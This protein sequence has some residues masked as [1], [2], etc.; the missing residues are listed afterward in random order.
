[1]SF[2]W[3]RSCDAESRAIIGVFAA[4]A[5]IKLLLLAAF[6]PVSQPDTPGYVEYA[7]QIL[8]STKW[9]HD[10]DLSSSPTPITAMRMVGYPA[11]IAAAMAIA[12]PHWP[13]LLIALQFAMSFAAGWALY[14]LALELALPWPASLAAVATFML[15]LQLT[16]DQALLTDSINS[17]CLVIS[18]CLLA[19]GAVAR[20]PLRIRQAAL[21]GLLMALAFL[22]REALQFLVI[23][24]A[25]LM[26]A[27]LWLAGRGRLASSVVACGLVFAPL[28]V[29]VELYKAWNLHRTGERFVTTI[30]TLNLV[31]AIAQAAKYDP[32]VVA[33]DTPFDRAV[34]EQFKDNIYSEV[35]SFNDALF[36][37]GIRAT[38]LSRMSYAHYYRA[39]REQP[40]AMLTVLR[41]HISEREAK[42]TIRPLAAIC[43][44]IEWATTKPGCYDY[45]DLYRSL[46]FF[47]GLPWTA[48]AFFVLQTAE[49]A[50]A[51]ALFGGFLIGVPCLIVI[52]WFSAQGRVDAAILI[53]ASFWLL[54][55]GWFTAY[56]V[57]H[58]EDRYLAPVLPF[59]IL[60]GFY[61]WG[62]LL[63]KRRAPVKAKV[64]VGQL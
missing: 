20:R 10:A 30:S 27:R 26:A 62:E 57:V 3:F 32:A 63:L 39:W 47:Q 9:L 12:G 11:L 35:I 59:S 23:T 49:I 18:V 7:E 33:G 40:L 8:R 61:V 22:V 28:V 46:P 56:G 5:A 48:P 25:P 37:Q 34:R 21:A 50:L 1:M 19:S 15:S 24:L 54:Y 44:T 29:T 4:V 36:N 55:V 16:L 58:I 53:L 52:G 41:R 51:I 2:R 64:S 17:S 42:L 45:R 38:D 60:G 6:G 31:Q 14:R 13:Y 43:E